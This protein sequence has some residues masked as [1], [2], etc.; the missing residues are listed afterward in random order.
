MELEFVGEGNLWE[1][2]SIPLF[3]LKRNMNQYN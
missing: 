3:V 2:P 1:S